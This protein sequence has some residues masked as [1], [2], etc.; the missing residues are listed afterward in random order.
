MLMGEKNENKGK[1]GAKDY[2]KELLGVVDVTHWG[3]NSVIVF[4]PASLCY[5]EILFRLPLVTS[6]STRF[7]CSKKRCS[8][9]GAAEEG[10]Q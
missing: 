6:L 1:G 3:Q 9:V 5:Y 7:S 4:I 2:L 8:L 10:T